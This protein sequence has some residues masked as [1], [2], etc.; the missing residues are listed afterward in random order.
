MIAYISP[1]VP[2]R[3]GIA[4]Y[5]HHLI[6][7][8]Q[9]ALAETDDSLVVF[10]DD[11]IDTNLYQS[12]YKA[13]EILP[14]TFE[15]KQREKYSQFIYHFGNNPLFH[16]PMLHLLQRKRGIVVLHDTVLYYL[17]AGQGAGGI[18]KAL[19]QQSSPNAHEQVND[20]IS[21]SPESNVLRYPS[22]ANY[23]FLQEVLHQATAVIV[24]SKIAKD[25]VKKANYSGPVYQVPLIDYLQTETTDTP[26]LE[27]DSLINLV[28]HKSESN[29]FIIGVFGFAGETKRVH[30]IFQ[31][32]SQ[33]S[34]DSKNRVKLM[35]IG[36]DQYQSEI[37]SMNLSDMVIN[38]GYVNDN[39]YN[40]S[41]KICDL[42]INLRYPSMGETSA[43][44]IQAMSA[45]K[46]TI[47]SDNGWF[48]ELDNNSVHKITTSGQEIVELNEA[49]IKM[50]GD[51]KYRSSMARKA[52]QYVTKYHS[53]Q[54][55]AQQWLKLISETKA[56]L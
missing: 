27:N 19:T 12:E 25:Y 14:L 6:K 34:E 11:I 1:L 18:W 39:D 47:V 54:N 17:I 4:L 44:Q 36:N 46:A 31:A 30:S 29:I 8:L 26:I 2:K 45:E 21:G 52:K 13:R 33:L 40:Y 15:K 7:A 37:K 9:L 53:P 3:T 50:M 41:M 24:H 20:I 22:P 42:I 49:I 35:V 23:P 32:L 5:S 48:S 55:V 28:K 43:V 10:D 56:L 38:L 51:D 16:Q